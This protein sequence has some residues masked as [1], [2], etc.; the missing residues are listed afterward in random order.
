MKFITN[1][2]GYKMVTDKKSDG[3]EQTTIYKNGQVKYVCD[4]MQDGFAYMNR[5]SPK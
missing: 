1:M 4:F 5:R 3:A 2:N